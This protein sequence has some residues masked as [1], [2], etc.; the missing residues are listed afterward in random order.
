MDLTTRP[1]RTG[2]VALLAVLLVAAG[3]GNAAS[4][5]TPA[6]TPTP[7]AVPTPTPAVSANASVAPG[8]SVA[9]SGSP[10][11]SAQVCAD[12][13][14]LQSSLDALTGMDFATAG[15][16]GTI[17]A[18]RLVL[19]NGTAFVQSATAAF[20]PEARALGTALGG[21][22]AAI[23]GLTGSGTLGDKA[24]TIENAVDGVAAAFDALKAK[25]SPRCSAASPALVPAASPAAS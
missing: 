13:A 11:T 1:R 7:T 21:L 5:P 2:M 15:V 19:T 4:T 23:G 9:P 6:P 22:Q 3:C 24:A 14:T 16:L 8:A 25:V 20:G 10:V 18:V 12:L 17:S